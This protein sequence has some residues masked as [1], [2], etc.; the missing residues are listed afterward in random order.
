[1]INCYHCKIPQCC[2]KGCPNVPRPQLAEV[3]QHIGFH[4]EFLC[5][6]RVLL[7][8]SITHLCKSW[9]ECVRNGQFG[10]VVSSGQGNHL[11]IGCEFKRHCLSC[12]CVSSPGTSGG[13]KC[14][15][16]HKQSDPFSVGHVL[17]VRGHSQRFWQLLPIGIMC[18]LAFC[19][20]CFSP[21]LKSLVCKI[22]LTFVLTVEEQVKQFQDSCAGRGNNK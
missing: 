15:K 4:W 3:F 13:D 19:R 22:E 1:M 9:D 21:I 10:G 11:A 7:A 12:N 2:L 8:P 18:L 14:G 16:P 6:G 5:H 20:C 17:Y